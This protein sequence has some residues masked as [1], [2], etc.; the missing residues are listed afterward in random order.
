LNV[1][2]VVLDLVHQDVVVLP[3]EVVLPDALLA[4]LLD[5]VVLP[6]IRMELNIFV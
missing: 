4:V 1:E 6:E 3:E 2:L 5:V